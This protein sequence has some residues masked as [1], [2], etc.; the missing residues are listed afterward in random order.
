VQRFDF[1]HYFPCQIAKV[2]KYDQY[3]K[4]YL[5]KNSELSVERIG[6]FTLS[7]LAAGEKNIQP[8]FIT[9]QFNKRAQTSEALIDYVVAETGKSR[10]LIASDL[11]SVFE[12]ARQYANIGKAFSFAGLGTLSLNRQ[13]EYDFTAGV[14]T[15][16]VADNPHP[17][18]PESEKTKSQAG[19]NAVIMIAFLIIALIMG[20]LG[21]GIY[22]YFS[23]RKAEPVA[24]TDQPPASKD[25][26]VNH[27][28]P[29]TTAIVTVPPS[30]TPVTGDSAVYKFV[31]E[32]TLSSARAYKRYD[33]L[34]RMQEKCFLDSTH[35]DSGMAYDL[36]V[37]LKVAVK[38][39]SAI[40]DSLQKY[41]AR[42]NPIIIKHG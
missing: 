3:I 28:K 10:I 29:D 17:L 22:K 1:N 20:G 8:Q 42:T 23:Q 35:R 41:F 34:V 36:Y 39:T 14:D 19:K 18:K 4:E 16:T 26:T 21:W 30:V 11:S 7:P 12:D 33:D 32:T 27:Q 2:S 25:S 24:T 38:D 15:V 31:F 40:K 9:F 6:T 5:L 13:G 37:R